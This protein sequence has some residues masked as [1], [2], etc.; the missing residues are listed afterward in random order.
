MKINIEQ[1]HD[2]EAYDDRGDE[3]CGGPEVSKQNDVP[4]ESSANDDL[5]KE[6]GKSL[7]ENIGNL[8]Q[9]DA[10]FDGKDGRSGENMQE[11]LAKSGLRHDKEETTLF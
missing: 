3:I 6:N 7:V 1:L 9:N 8:A 5:S 2:N 10:D 11:D 4:G